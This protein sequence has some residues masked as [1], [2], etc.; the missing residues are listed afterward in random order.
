MELGRGFAVY[1]D[2]QHTFASPSPAFKRF[3]A[4]PK[5][6]LPLGNLRGVAILLILA[7]HCVSAYIV[8]QPTHALAFDAPPY[9]WRAFPIVDSERWLGFDL[10]CAF[11]FLYL[12]QLMFFLSG[13]F[14]WPSLQRKG[15]MAFLGHRVWRLGVPF[16]LGVFLLMPLAFYPVYRV[17]AVD[18]GW[19][20]YWAHWT[21]LPITPTG[22][23]WFLWFLLA[24]NFAAAVLYR[25]APDTGR[26]LAPFL[27]KTAT[28]PGRFFVVIVVV[29]A[30]AYLPLSAIYS[31]WKWVGVGP[32]EVQAA[33]APQYMLYFL[34][35]L[36]V[37][38]YSYDRG[39][40][41]AKGMLVQHW[42]RW[43]IGSFVAFF[44]WIIATAL[45]MK[46]P[47]SPVAVLQVVGDLG[48]VTFAAA[49]CFT[50]TAIF[51]R[52]ANARWPVIDSISEHAYGIYFFHYLFVVW[53]QYALLDFAAPAV[54]KGLAV[55]VGTVLLS[56]AASV[57][58]TRLLA[59]ARPLLA[60]GATLLG[61]PSVANGRFSE[62]KFS[63]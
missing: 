53:L 8:T 19:P 44:V 60:R 16:V 43:L 37:G 9:D 28:H 50:T 4:M 58:T 20:A 12:M 21:A 7:F 29:T 56:W 5:A 54:V 32:F 61:A 13:L 62:T 17:T 14:V 25:L 23:M 6:S 57:A 33:F 30:V 46:V 45:V 35:G 15:W 24:L 10:F 47:E 51:L 38:S 41:D 31:P 18:P 63:D 55:F 26:V 52:F 40:L 39:L 49:A 2:K 22:P 48:L 1:V 42:G 36:A 3:Q 11:A 27:A 59:S 34:F